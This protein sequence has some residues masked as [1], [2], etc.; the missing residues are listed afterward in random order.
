MPFGAYF[1]NHFLYLTSCVLI[2]ISVT[3]PID[4]IKVR[5]QLD[6][7]LAASKSIFQNR[8]Y[9]GF[10]QGILLIVN[11]EGISG[12][13]KGYV[14]AIKIDFIILADYCSMTNQRNG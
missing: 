5:L 3:N 6:N 14:H 12:L 1:L 13:F 9:H 11:Q 7:E 2:F 8:K 10:S 4:V